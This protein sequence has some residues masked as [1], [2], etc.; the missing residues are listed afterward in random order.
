M[1]GRI[2]NISLAFVGLIV[3]AGFA[4]GAEVKQYF[5]AFGSWGMLGAIIAAIIMGIVGFAIL[6]LGSY[7]QAAEHTVVFNRISSP[8]A[9]KILDAAVVI[10]LFCVGFVMFAGAGANLKQQFG[11]PT[12]VG[13][14]LMLVLILAAGLADVEKASRIIGGITPALIFFLVLT[15]IYI[16]I[17]ADWDFATLDAHAATVETTLPNWLVSSINYVGFSV[18]VVVSMAI[19]MGG[20]MLDPKEAGRG[21]L[22]GGLLFGGLLF[23]SALTMYLSVATV[24]SEELPMLAVI[25]GMGSYLG[26]AMSI[27][28]YGMIFNTAFGMFYPLGKRMSAKNP[29]RFRLYFFSITIVGYILSAVGF[30]NLIGWVYPALGYAGLVLAV[31]ICWGWVRSRKDINA[32]AAARKDAFSKSVDSRAKDHITLDTPVWE[33]D[34]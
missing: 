10:N 34:K 6:E 13:A 9:A 28:I 1:T 11:L 29:S 5:V 17:K 16:M 19:C 31:V 3:G 24:G 25:N 8:L 23:L 27:V 15:G 7:L 26:V 18:I 30:K 21:G 4:S 12:W 20:S 2:L 32:E 33:A 22:A 14:T